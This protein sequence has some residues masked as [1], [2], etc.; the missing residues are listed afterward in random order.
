MKY[1]SPPI[2]SVSSE[3]PFKC[4]RNLANGT[5]TRLKAVIYNSNALL[6]INEI[7]SSSLA[8][9][10]SSSDEEAGSEDR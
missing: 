5:R 8:E 6:A 2:S 4:A 1:L 9:L 3:R 7:S 10:N